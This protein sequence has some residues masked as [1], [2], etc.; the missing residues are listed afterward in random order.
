M[1][2]R[3]ECTAG[4]PHTARCQAA[5][6]SRT[7]MISL[8]AL[9]QTLAAVNP[10]TTRQPSAASAL[11][12]RSRLSGSNAPENRASRSVKTLYSIAAPD[13]GAVGAAETNSA[14]GAARGGKNAMWRSRP[15]SFR[16]RTTSATSRFVPPIRRERARC[17][18]DQIEAFNR[19]GYVSPLPAFSGGRR[20]RST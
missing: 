18:A 11:S 20:H 16:P 4:I 12:V 3:H 13:V 8:L 17:R 5:A 14:T 2:G 6:R 7:I 19:D 1:F 15:T 10:T 9:F